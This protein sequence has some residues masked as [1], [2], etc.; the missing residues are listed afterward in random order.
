MRRGERGQSLLRS[1]RLGEE[2][3]L[4]PEKLRDLNKQSIEGKLARLRRKGAELI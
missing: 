2:P 4:P 3:L 1:D